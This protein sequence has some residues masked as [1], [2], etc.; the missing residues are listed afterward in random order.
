MTAQR[1][2]LVNTLSDILDID[3]VRD[4]LFLDIDGTL[5]NIVNNPAEVSVPP[6]LVVL[7]RQ[8]QSL[9]SGAVAVITGRQIADVD[10]LFAPLK[11]TASGVHG[12]E[13]R[14]DPFRETVRYA[15]EISTIDIAAIT[16]IAARYPGVMIEPK[17]TGVAVH[18]RNVPEKSAAL[19]DDLATFLSGVDARLIMSRGRM[20]FEI[21]PKGLSKGAAIEH[22]MHSA[23]FANRRPVMI[24]DDVGD[25]PAFEAV[26]RMHGLAIR[27][28]GEHF[29]LQQSE[30]PNPEAVRE[31]LHALASKSHHQ[32]P[33]IAS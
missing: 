9:F 23:P 30:L 33:E 32:R 16:V 1:R 14:L 26:R 10:R 31:L 28:A 18:Y 20:V 8:L 11:L 15:A 21:L 25:I 4:A 19:H 6:N 22:L 24:G 12:S 27:V 3:P 2:L 17:G 5:L 7:L 29:K 13:I